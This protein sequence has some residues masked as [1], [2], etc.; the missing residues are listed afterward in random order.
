[1]GR[2]A[3]SARHVR[4]AEFTEYVASRAGWLRKVAYLLCSDWH[5]A[6]DLVQEC[7][8]KLYANW[9]RVGQVQNRDGYARTVLVNTYLAEQR[10]PWWRRIRTV[11][12]EPDAGAVVA[13]D[14]DASL[15][16]RQALSSLPPR[17]R[18]AVVLRYYCDLT[19]EQTADVL[20]CST[21]NVKSQTSRGLA[22]LRRRVVP[23]RAGGAEA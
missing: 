10:S 6:D 15:D 3:G 18:A 19:V 7:I 9:S 14:L 12:S 21:G 11:G 13:A 17:Q 2:T 23:A 8:T 16:L 22:A 4:D 1:M 5:R 20:G